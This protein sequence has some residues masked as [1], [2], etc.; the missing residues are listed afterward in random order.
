MI[1][2]QQ[3][4]EKKLKEWSRRQR[5]LRPAMIIYHIQS[6][7]DNVILC[8]GK[9]F[10]AKIHP[11][12]LLRSTK[13]G[14]LSLSLKEEMVMDLYFLLVLSVERSMRVDVSR[15]PMLALVVVRCTAR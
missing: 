7:M 6:L 8:S 14:F 12:L 9:G 2:V 13:I 10:S 1:Y 15:V 3:I 11:M 4:K 5:G